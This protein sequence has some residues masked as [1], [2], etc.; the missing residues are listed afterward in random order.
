MPRRAR[1]HIAVVVNNPF[2]WWI[3]ET[4]YILNDKDIERV[5]GYVLMKAMLSMLSSNAE[6]MNPESL[7]KGV[8]EEVLTKRA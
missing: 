6:G 1:W 2:T 7:L 3:M 8:K 5:I 4:Q